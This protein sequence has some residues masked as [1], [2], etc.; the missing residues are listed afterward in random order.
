MKEE[1]QC[2]PD[3]FKNHEGIHQ[4]EF[5][6]KCGECGSYHKK[7]RCKHCK[8]MKRKA[9]I[10]ENCG[11]NPDPDEVYIG[12]CGRCQLATRITYL[13]KLQKL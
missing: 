5:V 6:G 2:W 4:P 11:E 12:Y 10:C 1:E 9:G 8:R 13:C 3:Y 7:P